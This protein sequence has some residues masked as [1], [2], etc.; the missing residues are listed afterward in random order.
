MLFA[1]CRVPRIMKQNCFKGPVVI[2]GWCDS[3]SFVS[4]VRVCPEGE[5]EAVA[6]V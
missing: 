4:A 6:A 1:Q 2:D 3:S 5:S